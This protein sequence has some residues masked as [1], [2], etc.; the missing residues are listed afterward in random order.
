[1]AVEQV[2]VHIHQEEKFEKGGCHLS[3]HCKSVYYK[4]NEGKNKQRR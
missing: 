1:M 3:G 4:L 2:K